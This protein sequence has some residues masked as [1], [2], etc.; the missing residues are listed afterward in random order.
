MPYTNY[1]FT[2][3]IGTQSLLMQALAFLLLVQQDHAR[4]KIPQKNF[5]SVKAQYLNMLALDL[6]FQLD[7]AGTPAR[8]SRDPTNFLQ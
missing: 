3:L 5:G 1:L 6:F 8:D 7:K 2:L 4:L